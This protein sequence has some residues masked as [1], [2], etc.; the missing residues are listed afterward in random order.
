MMQGIYHGA[1]V[2]EGGGG[3]VVSRCQ[4]LVTS[5]LSRRGSGN[6]R[7][8]RGASTKVTYSHGK[9][10]R[11]IV[12]LDIA[13]NR[14]HR[15][16]NQQQC[17]DECKSSRLGNYV[18]QH[19]QFEYIT[20]NPSNPSI[21]LLLSLLVLRQQSF[22]PAVLFSHHHYMYTRTLHALHACARMNR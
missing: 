8:G 12:C 16:S 20:E 18:G 15:C 14:R 2:C 4:T 17:K 7:L 5:P 6:A 22:N 21:L 3:G 1:G 11:Q 9:Q 19:T 10:I 13:P